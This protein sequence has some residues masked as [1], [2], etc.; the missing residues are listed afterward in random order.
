MTKASKSVLSWFGPGP[1][2]KEFQSSAKIGIP[3][4]KDFKKFLLSMVFSDIALPPFMRLFLLL[5]WD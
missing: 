2:G 3:A 1:T 5:K 4:S